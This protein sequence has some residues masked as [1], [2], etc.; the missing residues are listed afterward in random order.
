MVHGQ[1]V[2]DI[3]GFG[4]VIVA[5]IGARPLSGVTVFHSALRDHITI[6]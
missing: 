1:L 6:S 5:L 2:Q 4:A 3:A